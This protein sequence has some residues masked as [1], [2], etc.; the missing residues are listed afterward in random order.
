MIPATLGGRR[1]RALLHQ[2]SCSAVADTEAQQGASSVASQMFLGSAT[3]GQEG[4]SEE[5][6]CVAG[7]LV[8]GPA[9]DRL[10]SGLPAPRG[11]ERSLR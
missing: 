9:T 6:R 10:A 3:N 5:T 2:P 1:L 4:P 11:P 7:G 8:V